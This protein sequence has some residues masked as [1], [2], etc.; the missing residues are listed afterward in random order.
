[1]KKRILRTALSLL[2]ALLLVCA[3][4]GAALAASYPAGQYYEH[5]TSL[6]KVTTVQIRATN[7]RESAEKVE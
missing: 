7:T 2:P 1:M 6:T 5:D 3:A 4:A